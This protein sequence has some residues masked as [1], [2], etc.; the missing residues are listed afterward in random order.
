MWNRTLLVHL[1]V[2]SC[3]FFLSSCASRRSNVPVAQTDTTFPEV[4]SI[5]FRGNNHVGA[6]ALRKA[7]ATRARPLWPFWR[8]GE[9]YNAPTI[10]EDVRRLQKY[11]FDRGFLE[12]KAHVADIEKDE[13]RNTVRLVIAIDEGSATTV[14]AVHILGTIP[15]EVA[16]V[17]HGLTRL[18][19]RPGDRLAKEAFEQT[20]THLLGLLHAGGYARA[21]VIPNTEVNLERHEAILAFTLRPGALTHLGRIRIK[22]THE[23]RKKTVRRRVDLQ[24]GDRYD[25][26]QLAETQQMIYDLGMFRAVTPRGVNLDQESG[27]LDI[28]L[29]VQERK[30]RTLEVGLGFSTVS[31]FR[32]QAE[33]LHRN[34]FHGAEHLSLFGK[35]TSIEQSAEINMHLPYFLGRRTTFTQTG[36]VRNE[37]ELGTD[38]LGISDA[39]FDIKEAQPAF[40]LLSIG[41][42]SRVNHRLLSHLRWAFGVELSL[43]NV[44]NVD[45]DALEEDEEEIA[46]DNLL[47]MQFTQLHWDTS[48]DALNPTSGVSLRGRFEHS[49]T[50]VISDVS[51]YKFLF[52]ARHYLPLL[53]GIV[54][55]TRVQLGSVEPYGISE[56]VPFNVRFFAGGPGSLRGFVIN[57]VGPR[58]DDDEPIGGRSLLE[59]GGELR[60]PIFSNVG[61]AVFVDA[62]NVFKDPFV[63]RVT[64]MRY[65]VGPGLRYHSPVGVIRLDVGFI[66]DR[67]TDED[68]FRVEFSIGQAF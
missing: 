58:D 30:P 37:Q 28:N 66:M 1:C 24:S 17:K 20:K 15:P 40:D 2:V 5:T 55:A 6:R 57:R 50:A 31:R 38:P 47:L 48:N 33:W 63:Y 61:G 23:V 34:L 45:E 29:E 41:G 54:L 65:A 18:P 25:P 3:L 7:M 4:T 27:P 32:L 10:E 16:A 64:Q 56:D 68:L 26:R 60:F 46:E 62:G 14:K 9:R 22:G 44:R 11:Y 43:N 35:I 36:F 39:L 51:F 8:P 12:A 52:E 13:D 21:E 49:N 59:A 53:W 42:V 19:I 67:R